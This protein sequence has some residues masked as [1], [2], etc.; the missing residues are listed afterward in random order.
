[1]RGLGSRPQDMQVLRNPSCV[2]AVTLLFALQQRS[3]VC[4]D[5]AGP[6][7][8]LPFLTPLDLPLF[9]PVPAI[10][11]VLSGKLGNR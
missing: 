7:P 3:S 9:W 10:L 8:S 2:A 6:L 5:L 4:I 1:M 11:A